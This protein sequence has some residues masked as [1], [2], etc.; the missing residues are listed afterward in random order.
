[1]K[2]QIEALLTEIEYVHL[3]KVWPER[4][5]VSGIDQRDANKLAIVI[6]Q[7]IGEYEVS[8]RL[9]VELIYA[10]KPNFTVAENINNWVKL[11]RQ[12]TLPMLEDEAGYLQERLAKYMSSAS[13]DPEDN[14]DGS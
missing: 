9:L 11:T 4:L 12:I 6:G 2:A 8:L 13:P 1:L 14:D 5:V 7:M 3:R 10:P